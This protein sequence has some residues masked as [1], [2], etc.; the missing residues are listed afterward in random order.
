MCLLVDLLGQLKGYASCTFPG[1][2]LSVAKDIKGPVLKSLSVAYIAKKA[3]TQ[4]A[5]FPLPTYL[6]RKIVI[7]VFMFLTLFPRSYQGQGHTERS[8]S[9]LTCI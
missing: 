8:R 2:S 6:V 5:S 9:R 4:I 7:D 3:M 1:I